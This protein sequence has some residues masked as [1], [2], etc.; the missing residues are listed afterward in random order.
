MQFP[1]T[2]LQMNNGATVMEAA[3]GAEVHSFRM[4]SLGAKQSLAYSLDGRLLAATGDDSARVDLW[5]A[6]THQRSAS[7]TGHTGFVYSV[8]FSSDG[9]LLASASGDR[10]VRVWNAATAECITVLTGHTDEVFSA[11][12]HPVFRRPAGGLI[13]SRQRDQPQRHLRT[14]PGHPLSRSAR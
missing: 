5:D 10:T 11:V 6:R 3:T 13:C 1:E 2:I 14:L 4:A 8:A 9:R 12:F 7:L